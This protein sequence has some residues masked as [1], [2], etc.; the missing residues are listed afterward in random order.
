MAQIQ[1]LTQ[2]LPYASGVAKK[3]KNKSK[4]KWE[5]QMCLVLV[6]ALNYNFQEPKSNSVKSESLLIGS[7]LQ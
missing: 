2:E 7:W 5:P 3:K 6:K 4:K 1:C